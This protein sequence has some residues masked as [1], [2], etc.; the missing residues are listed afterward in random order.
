ME[1]NFNNKKRGFIKYLSLFLVFIIIV[2]TFHIDVAD[3][4]ESDFVQLVI[5]G[6]KRAWA[7]YWHPG[8]LY[9]W[10]HALEPVWNWVSGFLPAEI[11]GEGSEVATTTDIV[12]E[13]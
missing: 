7:D 2:T 5:A 1:R 8:L 11:G 12:I 10:E 3:I 9:A 13:N 6:V 4:V